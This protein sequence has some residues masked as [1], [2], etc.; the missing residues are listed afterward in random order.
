MAPLMFE[1]LLR[2]DACEL[3]H[4]TPLFGIFD[5]K[6]AELDWGATKRRAAQ[7]SQFRMS[8]R[9]FASE[10]KCSPGGARRAAAR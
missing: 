7:S 10:E 1:T 8:S 3:D 4:L 9:I 6:R 2:L 5:D